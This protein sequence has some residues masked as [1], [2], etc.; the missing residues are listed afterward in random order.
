M[1]NSELQG[2]MHRSPWQAAYPTS[3]L[4]ASLSPTIVCASEARHLELP[5]MDGLRP[6]TFQPC[7]HNLGSGLPA[8]HPASEEC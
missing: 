8:E 3:D 7:F 4:S 2:L 1:A 6:V 5:Q